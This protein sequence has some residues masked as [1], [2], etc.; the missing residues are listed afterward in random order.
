MRNVTTTMMFAF[1]VG[2]TLSAPGLGQE[3]DGADSGPEGTF[4]VKIETTLGSFILELNHTKAPKTVDNFLSYVDDGFYEGTMFHRVINGFMIQGGGMMPNYDT[5]ETKS[6]VENEAD[7]GLKNEKY[8]VAM[9]RTGNP[10]SATSQ[11]FVNLVNNEF[12][13]HR[14]KSRDWGYCVFG[15][16]IEGK[17]TIDAIS[18]TP[19]RMDARADRTKPAAPETPVVIKKAARIP[20]DD[21]KETVK[22]AREQSQADE[23]K[24]LGNAKNFLA[25][26]DVDVSKGQILPSG[27]WIYHVKEGTGE[28]PRKTQ[29]VHCHYTG[30]LADGTKFSSSRDKDI[31]FETY[32]PA[33]ILGWKQTLE[34][35]KPGGRAYV[36]MPPELGYGKDG[37]GEI[38]PPDS[39]LVFEV[40]LLKI[41][42]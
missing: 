19:V 3:A 37:H 34:L 17:D 32:L 41:E 23:M 31:V 42:G 21:V 36:I 11:F 38:I 18:N 4:Y 13:N 9:A 6:P 30:W 35:M 8:T 27:L 16:V 28:S 33:L 39:T 1:C 20:F 7:N 40:E 15:T 25:S 12:L 24:R 2:A 14:D 10:H 26:M 29:K 5:K 22:K